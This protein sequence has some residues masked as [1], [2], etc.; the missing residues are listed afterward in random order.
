LSF[1]SFGTPKQPKRA[2]PFFADRGWPS[3]HA[4][5]SGQILPSNNRAVTLALTL[6]G[7]PYAGAKSIREQKPH[8]A[9][10]EKR[11]P[12]IQASDGYEG[13][14]E[15]QAHGTVSAR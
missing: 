10:E 9:A 7:I 14:N 13:E 11:D 15:S 5:H 4:L 3:D 6:V 2:N 1:S 8:F 12:A